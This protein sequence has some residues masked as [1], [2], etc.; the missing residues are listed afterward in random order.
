MLLPW[1]SM[2]AKPRILACARDQFTSFGRT[3]RT[4][5]SSALFAS[6]S[7][8]PPRHVRETRAYQPLGCCIWFWFNKGTGDSTRTPTEIFVDLRPALAIKLPTAC[9]NNAIRRDQ[10]HFQPQ[11]L[12]NTSEPAQDKIPGR[13][14]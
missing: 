10:C 14:L 9:A 2:P 11:G 6:M 4:P 5:L 8:R 3:S 13:Y 7:A 12:G 1:R